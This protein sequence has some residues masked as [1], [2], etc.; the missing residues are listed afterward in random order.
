MEELFYLATDKPCV[1][2]WCRENLA[3]TRALRDA[4]KFVLSVDYASRAADI[5]SAC[6]R[7]RSERFAGTVTDVELDRITPP[8]N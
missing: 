3:D 5:A 8:C 2:D 4:G 6:A 1:Q 7:Y